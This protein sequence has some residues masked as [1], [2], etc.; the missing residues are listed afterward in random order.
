MEKFTFDRIDRNILER[1]Q[2]DGRISNA[3]LAQ[4]VSLSESACLRRTRR[5][6]DAGL[7][8]GYVGL[9]DQGQAGYPD[10]VFV[11]ITLTSQQQRDLAA[12]EE[13]VSQ[14]PEVMECYLMTGSRDYLLRVVCDGLK[15]YERFTRDQLATLPGIRSIE[16]SFALGRVKVARVLPEG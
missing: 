16:S 13:A 10:D 8:S 11:Q 14:L 7:I 5:L 1:I 6:E 3:N 2:L 15:S 4:A 9:V 12:F